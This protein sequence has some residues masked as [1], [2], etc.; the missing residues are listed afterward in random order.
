MGMNRKGLIN[1]VNDRLPEFMKGDGAVTVTGLLLLLVSA[2]V[3]VNFEVLND[4]G[5]GTL[6]PTVG[7][8]VTVPPTMTLTLAPT[9]QPT[10]VPIVTPTADN[11]GQPVPSPTVGDGYPAP[12]APATP[13]GYPPPVGTPVP[14]VT[15]TATRPPLAGLWGDVACEQGAQLATELPSAG[16][17]SRLEDG[18][19]YIAPLREESLT[20]I[21]PSA[22]YGFEA[23]F[24]VLEAGTYEFRLHVR[25]ET[26]DHNSLFVRIDGVGSFIWDIPV[27]TGFKN[28]QVI[29]RDGSFEGL[30]VG[31]DLSPVSIQFYMREPLVG[32][33]RVELVTK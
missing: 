13:M 31:N 24:L 21:G 8:V 10:V 26:I 16:Y 17:E 30:V 19:V 5:E 4:L 14:T 15:A 2:Y 9:E 3:A 28:Q 6:T 29:A 11:V 25:A 7:A 1:Y 20:G 33:A 18:M 27:A 12:P 23:C 32:V 22:D